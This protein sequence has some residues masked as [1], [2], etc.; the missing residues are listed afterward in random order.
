M[1]EFLSARRI[2]LR[3]SCQ[4]LPHYRFIPGE[5]PH[6]RRHEQGHSFGQPEPKVAGFEAQH[7][8]NSQDYKFA[9]DLFNFGF[10]WESHE[11]FEAFWH[12]SGRRTTEGRF[13]QGLIQ[14]AAAHLK[15]RMGNTAAAIRLFERACASL[16]QAPPVCMGIDIETLVR[17]IERCCANQK[18]SVVL[19]YLNVAHERDSAPG[20]HR[21]P[22]ETA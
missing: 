1:D 12:A 6:P 17:D 19:L 5:T 2:P 3:Y 20:T 18:D 8:R 4:P 13:F 16:R 10:W 11:L 22:E 7:W 9:L 21:P 14:L 15:R